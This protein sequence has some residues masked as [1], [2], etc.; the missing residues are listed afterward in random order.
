MT[1]N[2]TM[3]SEQ[4][5]PS[6]QTPNHRLF[7][8]SS[9]PDPHLLTSRSLASDI[10]NAKKKQAYG[11]EPGEPVYDTWIGPSTDHSRFVCAR[12][13]LR[14]TPPVLDSPPDPPPEFTE[15]CKFI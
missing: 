4:D 13:K 15:F 10:K 3:T 9:I 11:C 6:D 8:A 2:L 1:N 14:R 12:G 5:V 7:R